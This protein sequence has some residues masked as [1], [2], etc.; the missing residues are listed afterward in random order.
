VGRSGR[1]GRADT[2]STRRAPLH[3]EK[4]DEVVVEM[5]HRHSAGPGEE[6]SLASHQQEM[7][8][9]SINRSVAELDQSTQ[10]NAALVEELAATTESLKGHAERVVGAVGFFRLPAPAVAAA[11]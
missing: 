11:S 3:K 7:G 10:Q 1:G 2:P 4:R 8:I 5:S 9:G 6:V